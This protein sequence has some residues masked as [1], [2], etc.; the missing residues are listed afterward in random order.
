[1][2]VVDEQDSDEEVYHTSALTADADDSQL[3]ILKLESRNFLRF[4]V[5][6]EPSVTSFLST[7]TISHQ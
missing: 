7:Y 6:M 3:V 4:Q 1:M 2:K 5:D